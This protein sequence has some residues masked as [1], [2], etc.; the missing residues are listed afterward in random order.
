M[1]KKYQHSGWKYL[2]PGYGIYQMFKNLKNG[3][4][5]G[6]LSAGI[7]G[8]DDVRDSTVSDNVSDSLNN[9]NL[10]SELD[11]NGY[12]QVEVTPADPT[13]SAANV[14]NHDPN[15]S[16]QENLLGYA[17]VNNSASAYSQYLAN[18]YATEMS[19]TALSRAIADAEANGIS[20]YQLFQSG[21]MAASTPSSGSSTYQSYENAIKSQSNEP[22]ALAKLER[23]CSIKVCESVGSAAKLFAKE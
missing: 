11:A 3:Y 23:S 19:N 14:I 13:S 12:Q 2:I 4:Q 1:G 15:K 18:Q 21:N 16:A 7:L 22:I 17:K 20:K 10:A 6:D 9:H 8:F 5:P